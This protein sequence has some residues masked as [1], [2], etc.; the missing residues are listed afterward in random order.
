MH[1]ADCATSE[2][3]A[4]WYGFHGTESPPQTEDGPRGTQFVFMRHASASGPTDG[5]EAGAPASDFG[6]FGSE[7]PT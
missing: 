5:G 3:A 7:G 4:H 6:S 1:P 2:P